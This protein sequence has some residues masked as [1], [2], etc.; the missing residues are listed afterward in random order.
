[1][2]LNRLVMIAFL[3]GL[4]F[5]VGIYIQ[6]HHDSNKV[7]SN[8]IDF[9]KYRM[10]FPEKQ[11]SLSLVVVGDIMLSRYVAQMINE[12]GDPGYAF[13]G[14]K[15]FL[16]S[17]DI[18]F[19]NLENPITSGR[20]IKVPEMV[21]RADP[22][23]VSALYES[24]FN[25]LSLANNHIY[26]FGAQGLLDTLD[27][28]EKEAI[29]YVGAGKNAAE[30]YAPRFI[31]VNGV[32][33]AFLAFTDPAL[34]THINFSQEGPSIGFLDSGKVVS[35]VSKAAE[36]A[37][38]TVVYFHGGK[39]YASEPEETIIN[40]AHLAID[41]GADL[42]LGSHPHVVQKVEQYQGKFIFY[43]L[44]NFIFD[45]LWS[46]ET[47]ESIIA[48]ISISE[49]RVEKIEFLPVFINDECFPVPLSGEK[50]QELTEKLRLKLKKEIIPAWNREENSFTMLEQYVF[51]PDNYQSAYRLVKNRK[52]DLDGNGL[53][54]EF[55]LSNGRME[56][57][58]GDSLLWQSPEEWW[59]D[60]FFLGDINNDGIQEASLLVWKEGSFGPYRP[61]WVE[62][63]DNSVKNH[64]YIYKL[65]EGKIKPVWQSSNLD[66]P[67]YS[68]TLVDFDGDGEMELLVVEGSYTDF[69]LRKMTLWKW[70]GWGFSR[71]L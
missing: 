60:N 67:N 65:K 26:D 21:L 32:K 31:E 45:Q 54:E 30:A 63:E 71:I 57:W 19:G 46:Q 50:G 68:G 14:V 34:I 36:N 41:S 38:F 42:V 11:E 47:R 24:G 20:E 7:F 5:S 55:K 56:I 40:L 17:G 25:I 27:Y 29:S 51:Y 16:E 58:T 53:E 48:K 44:G 33:L 66:R 49:N 15:W 9:K 28:L 52:F 8:I 59:V 4:L 64:L 13:R 35:S 6:Q 37:D 3:V 12:Y 18:V 22:W 62:E 69:K 39:E 10:R 61:F 23:V 70:N 1:M 43:S 2:R